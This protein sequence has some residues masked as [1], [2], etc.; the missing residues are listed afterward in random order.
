MILFFQY[1]KFALDSLCKQNYL[2][3]TL[4]RTSKQLDDIHTPSSLSSFSQNRKGGHVLLLVLW[5]PRLLKS[6]DVHRNISNFDFVFSRWIL[7]FVLFFLLGIRCGYV[8][9]LIIEAKFGCSSRYLLWSFSLL[10]VY[11][12]DS[13]TSKFWGTF[14]VEH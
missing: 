11:N 13:L 3:P 1:G 12:S 7:T 5:P 4:P 6:T 8:I 10:A 14:F 2:S 9:D